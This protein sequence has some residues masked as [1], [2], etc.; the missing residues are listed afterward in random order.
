MVTWSPGLVPRVT[1]ALSL[2]TGDPLVVLFGP[3]ASDK[4]VGTD[5]RERTLEESLWEALNA[6]GY[7]RIAFTSAN[8]PAY[9]LDKESRDFIQRQI[10]SAGRRERG[11]AEGRPDV[12]RGVSRRPASGAGGTPPSGRTQSREVLLTGPAESARYRQRPKLTLKMNALGLLDACLQIR[13]TPTAV[14]IV[15]AGDFLRFNG[16]ERELAGWFARW[17]QAPAAVDN[18]C[19]LVFTEQSLNQTTDFVRSL[20]YVN[21]LVSCL[22]RQSSRPGGRGAGEITKPD[23]AE[24]ERIVHV[25]RL[26]DGL[27]IADWTEFDRVVAALAAQP[28]TP[29]YIWGRRLRR[30]AG[31]GKALSVEETRRQGWVDSLPSGQPAWDRLTELTGLGT[32]KEHIDRIRWRA[33]AEARRRR[34]GLLRE[35]GSLHL[36]FTGGPGT[37]KTTVARLIG[38]LYREMGVLRRGHLHAPEA[39]DLIGMYVG[40]TAVQTSQAVDAALDGVLFIDEAYRLSEAPG[41]F[42]QEAIDTLIT[43]MDNERDRL[44]V[45]VAGYPDKMDAFLRSNPGL[46]RRFPRGNIIAFPDYQPD[47]LFAILTH[48]LRGRALSWVPELEPLLRRVIAG[49]YAKRDETFGNAGEMRNLAQEL[50]T[51]WAKRVR[52]EISELV[53]PDDLPASYRE[54]A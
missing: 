8:A 19:V 7:Q 33:E 38:E 43:R 50:E 29:A 24:L 27:R 11:A 21:V 28:D 23:A 2:E 30:L 12:S 22:E 40:H 6:A 49:L 18:V 4:F 53:R 46:P 5:Y 41:G 34:E 37:G 15:R 16:A 44:V 3:G 35:P 14:V 52:A 13:D 48:M 10:W 31:S 51:N 17:P 25:A 54:F 20:G 32:V 26:R 45:I 47:E 36:I 39:S 1:D 9:F 42:G